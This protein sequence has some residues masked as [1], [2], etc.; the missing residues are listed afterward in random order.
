MMYAYLIW[1]RQTTNLNG[2]RYKDARQLKLQKKL[3]KNNPNQTWSQ[4]EVIKILFLCMMN[5]PL[6]AKNKKNCY[7]RTV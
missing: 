2:I 6:Y 3:N 1:K 7:Y 4:R 5:C